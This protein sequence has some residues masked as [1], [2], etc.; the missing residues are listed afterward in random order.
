MLTNFIKIA[1]RNLLKNRLFT[2]LNGLGLAIGLAVALTLLLYATDE[3]AF[4]R[5]Y[6]H[7][8][9]IYRVNLN[10]SFDEKSEQW[11]NAPNI[12]GPTMKAQLPVVENQVRLLRHNFG[13]TAFV[14]STTRKLTETK[15][16]W[17][18]STLFDVFDVPLLLGNPATALSGPNRILLSQ[19]S[20]RR[21][22][23]DENP[24]GMVLDVDNTQHLQVTG[25]YADFPATSSLDADLIGSFSSVKWASNPTNQSWSN[26]SFETYL[27]LRPQT[28]VAQ[29]ER[30]METIVAK[31]VPKANRF[32]SLYLQPLPDIHLHSANITNTS[33]TRV[34]DIRQVNIL[35]ILAGVVL[36]IA[37]INYMNL[38]TAQAQTRAKEVGIAKTVGATRS[39]LVGRFYAETAIITVGALLL[40]LVLLVVSLPFFNTLT[41]KQ[42][43]YRALFTPS[44][45]LGLLG[46]SVGVTLLAGAYPAIQLS[47]YQAKSLL[48]VSFRR[49]SGAGWLRQG[50]VVM[51]FTASLVLVVSTAIFY[52]QLQYIQQRK[53]GYEPT[54]V[55]ALTTAGAENKEQVESLK[56]SL[57]NLSNVVSVSRAQTYPGRSGSGRGLSKPGG[58]QAPTTAITTNRTGPE[59]IKTLGLRLVAGKTLP[60]SKA[61]TDTTVQVIV[62]KTAVDFLGYTPEQAIGKIAP[63]VFGNSA[64]IVGV[65]DDFHFQ[66]L[67]QPIGAYAFHNADT[68]GRPFLLVNVQTQNLPQTMRQ[69][70]A[71]FR[72]NLPNSA[73]EFMFLDQFLNSLYRSEQRTARVVLVFAGL[74][75]FIACLGLF[76]LATFIAE[77]RTKEIGVRKVL[78][79]STPSIVALL[80]K[81][82]LKLVFIAILIAS[83][84]AWYAMS[85]WLA[86]F[87]YRIDI[88]WWVFALAGVLAVGIALLT[89]SF[90]SIQA[91]L[92][93]P[94]KSLRSE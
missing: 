10:V 94:V 61:E 44:M 15:L 64:E 23:G 1:W 18:D 37:C 86:N 55:V 82:F 6:R 89:V 71:V 11:A 2:G 4:D 62:N 80:S 93:N 53:L 40:G 22:F 74:A 87:T 41:D 36:L 67:H 20:A 30:Q 65:V 59:I 54:Q 5:H 75:I 50:L 25:V 28:N 21:Y 45:A 14:N 7:A 57:S 13:Q 26:A 92:T 63:N 31:N 39:Q 51:Q 33:L 72:Q 84:L 69:L 52:R 68:E 47:A 56:N 70:E 43:S 91:A 34:G 16:Y 58:N 35:L 12:V 49:G 78:G 90:Q 42:I 85:Q 60:A 27:L 76:G 79:A 48:N 73:F 77:Q 38:A 29:L 9:R 32:Y 88:E 17:A 66:S 24:L 81:D 83:P 19:S 8:D 46:L 3:L